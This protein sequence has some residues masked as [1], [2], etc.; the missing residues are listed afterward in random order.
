MQ[1]SPAPRVVITGMGLISPVGLNV[2]TAWGN[3]AAGRSGIRPITLFDVSGDDDSPRSGAE[4]GW[5]VKIAGEAWGFDPLNYMSAKEARRADRGAQF[6][7]AAATEAAA[8]ARLTIT[9][10]NADDVGVMIG[11]GSGGL[12]TYT[13]QQEIFN[14]KGPQRMNPLLIP[15][16]VVDSPG[17]QVGIRFG[18]HGPNFGLASACSTGADAIGMAL[19]TIR[20]GDAKVMITGGAEAAVHPLGIAGFDNLGA[21]SRRNSAPAEASRPFDADRDGFV[22]S[23]GSGVLVIESLEYALARGAEPLAEIMAYA[24]TSDGVHFTAPDES[25]AQA[26]RAVRRALEKASLQPDEVDYINAHATSTPVGDPLEVRAYQK[27]FG[28]RS[29]PISSTKST[30]GHMLGAAGAV[31]AI[32][33]VQALR[34][35]LIPPTINYR[36]P[37]PRCV[38][39]CVPNVARTASLRVAVSSAFGFGGHNT[40]LVFRKFD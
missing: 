28:E 37:D 33:C 4:W 34:E 29:L 6:A 8:Q 11:S 26:A 1:P 36:T 27:V 22:L 9:P 7:L 21:L 19:E 20:R 12:W 35:G 14:T 31:A 17:V 3:V 13:A 38:L 23:E 25:A 5:R 40:I 24:G 32:W 15:M 2:P 30:T 39:D 16:E 18:A 10:A